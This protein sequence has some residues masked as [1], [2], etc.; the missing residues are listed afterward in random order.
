[1]PKLWQITGGHLT[2]IVT[3]HVYDPKDA[4]VNLCIEPWIGGDEG[5]VDLR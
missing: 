5:F 4:D 3:M 2:W 1:M